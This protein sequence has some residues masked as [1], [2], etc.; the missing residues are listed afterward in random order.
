MA[1]PP[2]DAMED[3]RRQ[4]AFL[5]KQLEAMC[6]RMEDSPSVTVHRATPLTPPTAPGSNWMFPVST[7]QT[8]MVGF[9]KSRNFLRIIRLQKKRGSLLLPS[10]ST[11][12]PLL[13]IN[14]CTATTKSSLGN[15]SSPP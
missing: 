8:R 14:G 7:E 12:P 10:I 4:I 2:P 15:S 11:E 1:P 9:L 13:G 6:K 5:T 3:M